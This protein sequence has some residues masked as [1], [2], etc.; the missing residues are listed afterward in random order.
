[1]IDV[2]SLSVSF[3]EITVFEDVSVTVDEGEIL[4]LVGP[5]GAGKTTLL[6]TINGVLSPDT[7]TVRIGGRDV[8]TLSAAETGRLVAT[9]PQEATV[10]FDFD[11]RDVVAMGRTPYLSRFSTVTAAD[12][13]A[14]D[15]ALERSETLQFADRPMGELSGGQKQ[16]V[17][18][19]RALAQETPILLL[20]EPTANLDINHQV[21]TLSM[22]RDLAAD[23][24][25]IVAAIHDLNLAARYC[26][27]VALLAHGE[28]LDVGPPSSVLEA[29]R[30][31][32]AFGVRTAVT[33]DPTTGTPIVTPLSDVPP[34]DSRVHV[35]GSGERAARTIGRLV[36]D[37]I[38]VTAGI[39]PAGDVAISTAR[40]IATDVVVAPPFEPIDENLRSAA[41][42]L[43][44]EADATVITS[45]VDGTNATLANASDRLLALEGT[46]APTRATTV[47]EGRLAETIRELDP[48]RPHGRS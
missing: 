12:R 23:G 3:D 20:D 36:D 21:A 27:T 43:I 18:F 2:E 34:G 30:L 11:V 25:A 16:R 47:R 33:T 4:A 48:V 24:K 14:V 46:E 10:A 38:E 28:L 26:D 29:G 32:S 42:T 15:D 37:G 41:E 35:I 5:N 19:G 22:A 8:E 44:A 9:V 39:L 1:M 6:R 40:G 7:G 17:M 13:A 45:A 31:E